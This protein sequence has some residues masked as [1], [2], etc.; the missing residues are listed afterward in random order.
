MSSLRRAHFGKMEVTMKKINLPEKKQV[1]SFLNSLTEKGIVLVVLIYVAISVG[2]SV[3][4]NYAMNQ[5]IQELKN[6]N[7]E[8]DQEKEYLGNLIAYY[9][10]DTFKELKAREELGFKRPGEF[11]LSVPVEADDREI[12]DKNSFIAP[13]EPEKKQIPNY[14][15]WYNYFFSG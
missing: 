15:K 14:Q 1:I 9:K 2:R 7:I 3:M 4:K 10:T 8:L 5:R 11:V 13:V 12:V 6:K